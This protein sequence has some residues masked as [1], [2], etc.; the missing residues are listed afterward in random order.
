MITSSVAASTG[1][2]SWTVPNIFS[3][4]SLVRISDASNAATTDLSNSVFTLISAKADSNSSTG[5]GF[6]DVGTTW[7]DGTVPSPYDTAYISVGAHVT[8]RTAASCGGVV[9]LGGNKTD[10]LTIQNGASLSI[11]SNLT[12]FTPNN[13]LTDTVDVSGSLVVGGRF[14]SNGAGGNKPQITLLIFPGGT[15]TCTINGIYTCG[16]GGKTN[17]T[18]GG[19]LN[20]DSSWSN[21]TAANFTPG[22]GT[23]G[24]ITNGPQTV[25]PYTYKNLAIGGSGLK[26]TTG[27]TVSGLLSMQ[28]TSTIS[29]KPT[30][31]T[32]ASLE[33]KGNGPQ[34][35]GPEL[36]PIMLNN[37]TVNNNSGVTLGASTTFKDTLTILNGNLLTLNNS[38][39]L[40]ST[41]GFL[42]EQFGDV[43]GKVQ[44]SKTPAVGANQIFCGIGAEINPA[45]G[46]AAPGRTTV[47]RVT[48]SV[49]A[50]DSGHASILRYFDIAPTK[51]T[52]LNATFKFHY[53]MS[54]LNQY[55]A[56]T[57]KLWKS[58]DTGKTWTYGG[59]S[60][61]GAGVITLGSVASFSRWTATSDTLT[62]HAF[63]SVTG[64]VTADN[65]VTM[66][67]S[68]S[69]P[70][71]STGFYVERRSENSRTFVTVSAFIPTTGSARTDHSY[72]WKD[73]TLVA[74]GKY[75]YRLKEMNSDGTP[76][77]SPEIAVTVAGAPSGTGGEL[78]K[79][80]QISQNYPNPFNPTTVIRYQLPADSRVT[81]KV[82]NVIGQEVFTLVDGVQ[83]AGFKEVSVDASRLSSGVYIYR[84]SAVPTE[85]GRAAFTAVRKML[86]VR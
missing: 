13:S 83:S 55:T 41:L 52:G 31:G 69:N 66:E 75:F 28:G 54:E 58:P 17:M 86:L 68:T 67:W 37:T 16:A 71:Q 10:R 22:L 19:T 46:S 50:A 27:V 33:Y 23:V 11:N 26:T 42:I 49:I 6:W 47:V 57:L 24:Y 80:F 48:G 70:A 45:A 51:N 59:G 34:T 76:S 32:S 60:D 85:A 29:V 39:T 73:E 65:L 1:T 3:A 64:H 72:S 56:G 78:P 5:D 9:L 35:T 40:D 84:M 12:M 7:K 77:Y 79:V 38:I 82:F 18:S 30:Y 74:P 61:N 36:L 20:L 2:Y 21:A 53:D 25:L 81:L 62:V 44:V 15:G 63:T 43:S 14:N 8:V 4:Q